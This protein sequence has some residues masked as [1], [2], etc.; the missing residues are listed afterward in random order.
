MQNSVD[1]LSIG[2]GR[3]TSAVTEVY[4]LYETFIWN[5][6]LTVERNGI[7]VIFPNFALQ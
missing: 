5:K 1:S 3:K 7:M 4:A 2:N 6:T